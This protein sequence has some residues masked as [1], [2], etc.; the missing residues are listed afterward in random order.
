QLTATAEPE[1]DPKLSPDGSRVLFRRG[2][3]LYTMDVASRSIKRLTDDGSATLL[4]GELDWV[5]PEELDLSTAF[6]W[7]PD[8]KSIAYLQLDTSHE[9]IY[10]QAALTGLRAVAEPERY[11]QSGTPNA[12]VRLGVVPAT[13]GS[14]RWMDMGEPRGSLVA[15]VYWTP[16]SSRLAVERFNRVQNQLDLVFADASNGASRV[17]LHESDPY[18]IN[19]NDLFQ[20]LASGEFIWG[21]ERDGF[22]HL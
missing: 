1:R 19:H 2:H 6:W 21:S 22:Q 9:F 8:S 7:S 3:D 18:W 17:I 13:G 14:T 4:N 15:R 11:P 20:F 10:P 12:D 5:Y 16:D